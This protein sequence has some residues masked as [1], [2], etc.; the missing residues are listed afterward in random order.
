MFLKGKSWCY[1]SFLNNKTQEKRDQ[2]P[3]C[4]ILS[5]NLKL[6]LPARERIILLFYRNSQK[7]NGLTFLG[8]NQ[9]I[10]SFQISK[11]LPLFSTINLFKQP[12]L[13]TFDIRSL[14]EAYY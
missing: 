12:S 6:F 13:L 5:P 11:F 3:T 7:D 2:T 10:L 1:L 4:M 8:R 14:P 9:R